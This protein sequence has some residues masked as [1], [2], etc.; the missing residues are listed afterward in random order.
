MVFQMM[1]KNTEKVCLRLELV[2]EAIE[3]GL[4]EMDIVEGDPNHPDNSF[5]WGDAARRMFVVT[6]MK[7]NSLTALIVW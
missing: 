5:V 4:W 6:G 3:V 1:Q 7:R 2:T